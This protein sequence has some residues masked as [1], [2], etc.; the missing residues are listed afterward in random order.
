MREGGIVSTVE[1]IVTRPDTAEEAVSF[2]VALL[3][4][5]A[6]DWASAIDVDTLV[7]SEGNR[8]VLGQLFGGYTYGCDRLGIYEDTP[9][10][11]GFNA[12]GQKPWQPLQDEW[13]RVIRLRQEA[14][15]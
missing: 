9:E 5:H 3:D 6:P 14:T 12:T 7:M 8:C 1:R 4:E 10:R 15:L 11:C 2:G 13:T